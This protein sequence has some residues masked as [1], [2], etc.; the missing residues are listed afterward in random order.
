[1]STLLDGNFEAAVVGVSQC[2]SNPG[3][4]RPLARA[5]GSGGGVVVV[6]SRAALEHIVG[7]VHLALLAE[8]R[9]TLVPLAEV[10]VRPSLVD[11]ECLAAR[12]RES[13]VP[14]SLVL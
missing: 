14:V 2:P 5:S 11:E 10:D 8:G 7:V 13:E 6:Q 4:S 9:D 12:R 1:M 3:L